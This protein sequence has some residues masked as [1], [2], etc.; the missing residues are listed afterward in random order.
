M[1]HTPLSGT[2]RL[3]ARAPRQS[4][5]KVLEESLKENAAIQRQKT[6]EARL[7]D[8]QHEKY[9]MQNERDDLRTELR[10]WQL[11]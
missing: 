2:S 4:T 5:V 9:Q 11:T 1:S 7:D 6:A 3:T 10:T 8:I